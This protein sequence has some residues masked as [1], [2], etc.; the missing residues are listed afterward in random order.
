MGMKSKNTEQVKQYMAEVVE[1]IKKKLPDS[2]HIDSV[3]DDADKALAIKDDDVGVWYLGESLKMMSEADIVF[4]VEGYE[5]F[6]GC[7]I[8]RQVAE[9]YGKY[10]IDITN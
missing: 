3:I 7:R 4:F 1:S 10:C 9:A 6:R 8:E 5:N 2:E